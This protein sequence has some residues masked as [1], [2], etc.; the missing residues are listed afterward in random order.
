V[1]FAG[2]NTQPGRPGRRPTSAMEY[3]GGRSAGF[4]ATL[5]QVVIAARPPGRRTLATSRNT[6]F[7]P[8]ISCRVSMRMM[9][10]LPWSAARHQWHQRP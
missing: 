8:G 7:L 9:R 6:P 5:L 4:A 3:P 2:K 1:F 10:P